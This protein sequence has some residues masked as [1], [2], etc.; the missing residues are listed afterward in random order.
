MLLQH[1]LEIFKGAVVQIA[2][3]FGTGTGFYLQKPNLIVT[4]HHVV[5]E[6]R[7]VVIEGVGVKRQVVAVLF[8]DKRYDLA[9]LD[10]PKEAATMPIITLGK[11]QTIL[12]G[13]LVL[14]VG[15]PFELKYT[16]TQGIVSNPRH[17]SNNLYYIQ[18]DAAINPGNSGGPLFNRQGEVV[19]V[20]TAIILNAN[21]IGFSLASQHL[22]DEIE[23][24]LNGGRKVGTRC[25][26]CSTFVFEDTIH[27]KEFCPNCGA[28]VNLP[29][30]L[31]DYK[32]EGFSY[33]IEKIL[34]KNGYDVRL[35]RQSTHSW[36]VRKGS[37]KID[38]TYHER[39]N[40]L[41]MCDAVL[42]GL[43]RQNIAPIYEYLLRQNNL[44]ENITFSVQGQDIILSLLIFDRYLHEDIASD[45]LVDL[46]EKADHYDNILVEEYGAI[47]KTEN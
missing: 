14:A 25:A 43:P 13:D 9:F 11:S 10:A 33:T 5:A 39:N 15:H 16:F 29:S 17:I 40:G 45:L 18:H 24:F 22:E 38:I 12:E 44:N 3:P 35:L 23:E 31:D 19:G 4:N 8:T 34:T 20:N 32:P 7:E 42:C 37:A 41:I 1:H 2:T 30:H 21:T 36:E 6:S 26:S 47:W 28:E 27:N 46:F